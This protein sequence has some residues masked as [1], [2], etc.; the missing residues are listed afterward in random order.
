MAAEEKTDQSPQATAAGLDKEL[1]WLRQRVAELEGVVE[2][3]LALTR[4]IASIEIESERLQAAL[5]RGTG[6]DLIEPQVTAA[7]SSQP[8]PV[9]PWGNAMPVTTGDED[10]WPVPRAELASV[11]E[12][13]R[14]RPRT[15]PLVLLVGEMEYCS[16]TG[17]S[18]AHIDIRDILYGLPDGVAVAM[19]ALRSREM[20]AQRLPESNLLDGIDVIQT[21]WP[22]P[23]EVAELLTAIAPDVI[24]NIGPLG[25]LLRLFRHVPATLA[26]AMAL[27]LAH[28]E[29]GYL[30]VE[31]IASTLA[32]AGL[33]LVTTQIERDML[34]A[35]GFAGESVIYH[36]GVNAQRTEF[37]GIEGRL[38]LLALLDSAGP[39]SI[40]LTG[41]LAQRL[42]ASG[43]ALSALGDLAGEPHE[44][45]FITVGSERVTDVLDA[46][47]DASAVL[48]PPDATWLPQSLQ[49][50]MAM[51]KICLL[52][53]ATF[54]DH[55]PEA[56]PGIR[57]PV[58]TGKAVRVITDTLDNRKKHAE[59]AT[60]TAAYASEHF[61]RSIGRKVLVDALGKRLATR[62][63][64]APAG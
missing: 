16:G 30:P 54:S 40:A 41:H 58:E 25:P 7:P 59:L 18:L 48:M 62:P 29:C 53:E 39:R 60:R 19:L 55:G 14:D 11:I 22:G 37:S 2:E 4:R 21:G 15:G 61:R 32:G 35:A 33:A 6:K 63:S 17:P 47:R 26:P 20:P 42:A 38:G 28:G 12:G 45:Q 8:A 46:I 56:L 36:H 31:A 57:Y 13:R 23:R 24:I 52:P 64:P 44:Q 27:N 9:V 5:A 50:A 34:A 43:M 49:V 1:A 10:E 51:G 3:N